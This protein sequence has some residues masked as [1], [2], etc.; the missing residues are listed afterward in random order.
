[1]ALSDVADMAAR[2]LSALHVGDGGG[3]CGDALPDGT[4]IARDSECTVAPCGAPAA[5]HGRPARGAPSSARHATSAASRRTAVGV[6]GTSSSSRLRRP[7]AAAAG[8]EAAAAARG[9]AALTADAALSAAEC[10]ALWPPLADAA[11][12]DDA[13]PLGGALGR[14]GG[15]CGVRGQRRWQLG[16]LCVR[17]DFESGNLAAVRPA[18]Q[19]AAER[20]A[21]RASQQARAAAARRSGGTRAADGGVRAA[22]RREGGQQAGGAPAELGGA[23]STPASLQLWTSPDAAGT[24]FETTHR[25]WFCFGVSGALEGETLSFSVMNLN[26]QGKLYSHGFRPVCKVAG[27]RRPW[28][29]L[30]LP[31]NFTSDAEKGVGVL[32]FRHRFGAAGEEVLFA[33]AVP[34]TTRDAAGC[35]DAAMAALEGERVEAGALGMA[36][37]ALPPPRALPCSTECRRANIAMSRRVLARSLQGRAVELVTLTAAAGDASK[38]PVFVLSSRVHPGETP[39]SHLFNGALAFLLRADDPRAAALREAFVFEM[40]PILNPDGVALG[41][42]RSDTRGA[43]LNRVYDSPDP[44]RAPAIAAIKALVAQ[45]A[46][47]GRLG[48]YLDLHAHANKRGCFAY[49]NDLTSATSAAATAPA[50]DSVAAPDAHVENV[51]WAKVVSLGCPHFDFSACNFSEKNMSSVDKS[52]ECKEAAGRVVFAREFGLTHCY[53]IECNYDSARLMNM[54][55]PARG[56]GAA[57]GASPPSR[58]RAPVRFDAAVMRSIGRALLVGVLEAR[59]A[60]PWSRLADSDY[61]SLARVRRWVAGSLLARSER[62]SGGGFKLVTR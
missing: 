13:A 23:S 55:A 48:F 41:H 4:G 58:T 24:E 43:N 53:T 5:S 36:G 44:E 54:V 59:G 19:R 33:F 52:G 15:G 17:A 3:A 18:A 21:E 12:L 10:V 42:Y 49:G 1:M 50:G 46:A 22:R 32:K 47:E 9:G 38:R 28:A 31:V 35:L 2:G 39:A 56:E 30:K 8:P 57:R 27:S 14:G 45:R 26:K 29:R 37:G 40:V 6:V 25:T 62:K 34:W 51:L 20:A 60:N 7:Q 11:P 61:G 16:R